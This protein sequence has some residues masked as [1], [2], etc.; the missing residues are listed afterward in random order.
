MFNKICKFFRKM[1]RFL[2]PLFVVITIT[3][4]FISQAKVFYMLQKITMLTLAITGSFLF[5]QI[6]YNKYKSKKR[7]NLK[8]NKDNSN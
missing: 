5:I 4:M 7:K 1:H 3:Y 8:T 6:Y 2:T